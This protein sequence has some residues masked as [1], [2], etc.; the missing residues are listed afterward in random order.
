MTV[1][2]LKTSKVFCIGFGK[3]G[4]TSLEHALK[5]FGFRMGNQG[6]GEILAEDWANKRAD[7]IIR[8]CETADAFQDMPFGLPGL[9]KELDKA[10]PNSKFILTVRDDA[11]QWFNSLTKF[12]A[13]LFATNKNAPPTEMDL[14]NAQYLYKGWVLDMFRLFSE[15]PTVELYHK[16]IYE[17]RYSQH[18]EDVKIYFKQ[19]SNDFLKLNVSSEGSYQRLASFLNQ[20]VADDANFPWLN[21]T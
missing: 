5:D 6:V 2:P 13:K 19:R 20:S 4:T 7:R 18:I 14:R 12:H 8:F 16:E 15:Y 17:Q 10:F 11:D 3:T 1:S 9:Y 21:K